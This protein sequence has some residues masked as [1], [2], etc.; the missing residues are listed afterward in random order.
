MA[1]EIRIGVFICDCGS[2]IRGVIDV[3]RLVEFSKTLP[4]VVLSDEGKWTCS[5]DYLS[6]MKE[7]I[8]EHSLNRVVVAACTPRTHEPLFKR[9]VKEVGLNPYLLEFVSIR[10]QASWVHMK[11]KEEATKKAKDL[12][13]MA[14]SKAALLEEGEEIRLPVGKESV[15]IGGGISGI[16]SALSLANQGFQVTLIER[17]KELGGILKR[18][19]SVKV[20]SKELD[21]KE[22]LQAKLNEI[23]SNSNIRY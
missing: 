1:E 17:E 14:V 8:K 20:D 16:Y 18:L 12:I 19:K 6:R 5:V 7:L 2:N 4:H 21:P 23:E 22:V 11:Q 3:P 9:T 10:E 15:V 13:K